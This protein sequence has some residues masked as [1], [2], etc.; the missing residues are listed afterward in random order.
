MDKIKRVWVFLIAGLVAAILATTVQADVIPSTQFLEFGN[1]SEPVPIGSTM[2]LSVTFT[3]N[4]TETEIF[5]SIGILYPTAEGVF[6]I[7]DAP[8]TPYALSVG[9]S[10]KVSISFTP[11]R[12][13]FD[14]NSLEVRLPD[15]RF[16]LVNLQGLGG[17]VPEV[18]NDGLD[19][20]DDSHVDC[21]DPDCSADVFCQDIPL[22]FSPSTV[23]FRDVVAGSADID[24]ADLTIRN[25]S[26][27]PI[28]ILESSLS[29]QENFYL[30]NT[31]TGR[32]GAGLLCSLSI[33]FD[34]AYAGE[35]DETLTFTYEGPGPGTASVQL[36]G[37]GKPLGDLYLQPGNIDFGEQYPVSGQEIVTIGNTNAANSLTVRD[38]YSNNPAFVID[39]AAGS[40]SCGSIFFT[41][42]PE[43]SC[44]IGVTFNP[45]AVDLTGGEVSGLITIYAFGIPEEETRIDVRGEVPDTTWSTP[46]NLNFLDPNSIDLAVEDSGE[47]HLCVARDN[48]VIYVYIDP[49]KNKI[50]KTEIASFPPDIKPLD[51]AIAVLSGGEPEVAYVI[52]DADTNYSEP[53]FEVHHTVVGSDVINRPERIQ[54]AYSDNYK[55]AIVLKKGLSSQTHLAFSLDTGFYVINGHA[56]AMSP[57]GYSVVK[58]WYDKGFYPF[59][60]AVGEEGNQLL[61]F[62]KEGILETPALLYGDNPDTGPNGFF[63]SWDWTDYL[64]DWSQ[65]FTSPHYAY[66]PVPH[67]D[68]SPCEMGVLPC[69][70]LTFGGKIFGSGHIGIQRGHLG[71]TSDGK[72]QVSIFDSDLN[73]PVYAKFLE[74]ISDSP[75]N[76]DE[77][78]MVRDTLTDEHMLFNDRASGELRYIKNSYSEHFVELGC[79]EVINP[80]LTES[81]G[82]IGKDLKIATDGENRPY[83]AF[84]RDG[85]VYFTRRFQSLPLPTPGLSPRRWEFTPLYEDVPPSLYYKQFFINNA[86]SKPLTVNEITIEAAPGDEEKW[87]VDRECGGFGYDDYIVQPGESQ[88]V[89]VFLLDTPFNDTA[90]LVISTDFGVISSELIA[91]EVR[92]YDFDGLSDTLEAITGTFPWDAD[93]DNDGLI[94]GPFHSED[95]NANGQVDPGETDPRNPDTDGDGLFDGLEKGLQEPQTPD[96]DL[97]EGFFVSDADPT[98]QTDPTNPDSDGDGILDGDEDSNHNG[99]YEPDLGE[100]DP[101]NNDS[102]NDGSYDGDDLC[103][104]DPGKA[105]PAVCGCGIADTDSDGDG[106]PDCNDMCANDPNKV[107]AGIC[108]CGVADIDSDG[109]IIVNCVDN[110]P[111]TPNPDQTDSDGNG[112]GDA[113]ETSGGDTTPPTIIINVRPSILWPPNHK[114][115][116]ITVTVTVSDDTDPN[117]TWQLKTIR[118]DE[119]DETN[120]FDPAHDDT[121]GDGNTLDDIQLDGENI[122]LRAERSG[123]GDGRVYT[124]TYQVSDAAGNVATASATVT[125]PHNI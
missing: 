124:I 43:E 10:V 61:V 50:T 118:M 37:T 64:S 11:V 63:L 23:E 92:D 31:C 120:T 66:D 16:I 13:S 62:S 8:E 32:I 98:T 101:L 82:P 83:A 47:A 109:D 30:G 115:V 85:Y 97:S 4:G 45:A 111:D 35:F 84:I 28:T 112:V 73:R 88:Y 21:D 44:T 15:G 1:W 60:G 121:Q 68:Y 48:E 58:T 72:P 100:T 117:P 39:L 78:T 107:E 95:L 52:R 69:D 38:I 67:P 119:G 76:F 56:T 77:F 90:Q 122:I 54:E 96:T 46:Q 81:I 123:K 94:G 79:N 105:E 33:Y 93:T 116:P 89:C 29:D 87:G 12:V 114:M 27:G 59:L 5:Q 18:C 55:A 57:W 7:E 75:L 74:A 49:V 110:C 102:D 53:I 42:E 40:T 41:L 19:N 26:D 17:A 108:G 113:C 2:T 22:S 65:L 71:T 34:P 91:A 106:I 80:Q 36:L 20:D 9:G 103:P 125:V 99:R 24:F 86:G 51:C 70:Q 14:S 6:A 104:H 3:N 25:T